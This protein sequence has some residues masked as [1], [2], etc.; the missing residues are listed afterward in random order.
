[1]SGSLPATR[2]RLLVAF[3]LV[4]VLTM[5]AVPFAAA[6]PTALPLIDHFD[7]TKAL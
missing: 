5:Y 4:V 3:L 2:G 6:A 7:T 1:M